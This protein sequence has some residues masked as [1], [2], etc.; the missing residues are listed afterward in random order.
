V[1][2]FVYPFIPGLNIS[3]WSGLSSGNSYSFVIS[4]LD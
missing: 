1:E 3:I 2:V 4:P